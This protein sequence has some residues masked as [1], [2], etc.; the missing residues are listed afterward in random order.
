MSVSYQTLAKFFL[1]TTIFLTT[2]VGG[3]IIYIYQFKINNPMIWDVSKNNRHFYLGASL[4]RLPPNNVPKSYF[5][6]LEKSDKFYTEQNADCQSVFSELS[7]NDSNKH[8]QSRFSKSQQQYL[9]KFFRNYG[10]DGNINEFTTTTILNMMYFNFDNHYG[11]INEFGVETLLFDYLRKA[12]RLDQVYAGGL[13]AQ[14]FC[15]T[16]KAYFKEMAD[17][18]ELYFKLGS[19]EAKSSV[20]AERLRAWR[21]GDIS[22]LFELEQQTEI[23]IKYLGIRN[24]KWMNKI[25]QIMESQYYQL[26][27][28]VVGASHI[29]GKNGMLS[30]LEQQGYSIKR[31]DVGDEW[32]GNYVYYLSGWSLKLFNALFITT[33]ASLFLFIIFSVYLALIKLKIIRS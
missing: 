19:I 11:W 33:A 23:D 5:D 27:F 21:T 28:I 24:N 18:P 9:Q 17:H 14:D 10:G 4:H 20:V 22:K 32:Q 12:H 26:T 31:L 6:V 30:L 2:I 16:Y 15:D 8:L 7:K 3:V 29:P 25:S 1:F 13:E